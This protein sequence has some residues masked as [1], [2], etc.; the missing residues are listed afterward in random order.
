MDSGRPLPQGPTPEDKYR[1]SRP[2]PQC[3][4]SSPDLRLHPHPPDTVGSLRFRNFPFPD[5]HFPIWEAG[6]RKPRLP[7]GKH[8]VKSIVLCSSH[9]CLPLSL[10]Q[11]QPGPASRPRC[12]SP[13]PSSGLKHPFLE[14]LPH[15]PPGGAH[16]LLT[17]PG[18]FT[19]S[20]TTY[21]LSTSDPGHTAG[22]T[23]S[24]LIPAVPPVPKHWPWLPINLYWL[25]ERV[26]T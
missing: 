20:C 21:S 24:V 25:N 22:G 5:H 13:P 10:Q 26:N 3:S 7:E 11:G 19:I 17:L 9:V 23:L 2:V 8:L 1:S 14:G 16:P 6:I 12:A 15:P 4:H 18:T